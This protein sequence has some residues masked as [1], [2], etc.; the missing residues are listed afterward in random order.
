MKN[1]I[2]K[3]LK[4]IFIAINIVSVLCTLLAAFGGYFSPLYYKSIPA[5]ASMTFPAWFVLMPILLLISYFV[6]KRLLEINIGTMLVCI[7][8]VLTFCPLNFFS[9]TAPEDS[10]EVKIMS[11]NAYNYKPYKDNLFPE[12]SSLTISAIIESGADIVCIQEGTLPELV[13][14]KHSHA[15]DI[16]VKTICQIYPYRITDTEGIS[17]LSKYPVKLISSPFIPGESGNLQIFQYDINGTSLKIYNIHLQSFGLNKNDKDLYI[18]LT[19]GNANNNIRRTKGQLLGKLHTS[20]MHHAKQAEVVRTVLDKDTAENV[21]LCGDFNDIP[22]CYALRT[23]KG[24]DMYDSFK[25][26]GLGP[27]ITYRDNR[28]YF[29]I[30]HFLCK[31]G[32]TTTDIR[33]IHAGASDHFPIMATVHL[34]KKS[35]TKLNK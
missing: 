33:A 13:S 11:Y 10:V 28:F 9:D 21:V 14:K 30:D 1:S 6:S 22:G 35:D 20:F 2:T 8:A 23:I 12:D 3:I 31:K 7:S 17:T 32:V 34:T 18:Q 15:T 5:I 19:K 27:N 29:H 26:C 25:K 24:D 4:Y 16:Q